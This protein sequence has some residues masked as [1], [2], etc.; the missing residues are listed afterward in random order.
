MKKNATESNMKLLNSTGILHLAMHALVDDQ[1]PMRSRLLF[2]NQIDSIEDGNLYASEIYNLKLNSNLTVLSACNTGFGKI[3]RGEGIMNLSRAFQYAGSPNIVM[4]LWQ[5][6]DG[7]TN[8]IMQNFFLNLKQGLSKDRAL[9]Q[10]KLAY[11]AQA[12]PFQ[13]H[14]YQ[15]A[16][17][18][19]MGN[20]DP[21]NFHSSYW[22]EAVLSILF[23]VLLWWLV[24]RFK[25]SKQE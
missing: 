6:T 21:V 20:T 9:R 18:I 1:D 11:L 24:K 12:D 7:S 13:S 16:T 2:S 3:Q 14:P 25:A 8:Q 4:S 19:Y 5:A 22:I 15:W 10:A 17:F 23:I